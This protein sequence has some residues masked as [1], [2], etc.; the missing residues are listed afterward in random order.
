VV[1]SSVIPSDPAGNIK[2]GSP[3]F[4]DL[5]G[6]ILQDGNPCPLTSSNV[7]D[8]WPKTSS[9][10]H[11]DAADRNATDLNRLMIFFL[12]LLLLLLVSPKSGHGKYSLERNESTKIKTLRAA[13]LTRKSSL[14]RTDGMQGTG[15]ICHLSAS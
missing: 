13:R 14:S 1:P 5:A 6:Q 9:N 12:R 10:D 7:L 4:G 11:H 2:P 8:C 3:T 15:M